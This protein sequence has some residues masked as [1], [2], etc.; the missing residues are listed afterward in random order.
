MWDRSH[1]SRLRGRG[2]AAHLFHS[3]IALQQPFAS[4]IDLLNPDDLD[5]GSDPIL[6]TD[7]QL[8]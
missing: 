2:V 6:T 8:A 3:S 5:I 1:L 7:R 4:L